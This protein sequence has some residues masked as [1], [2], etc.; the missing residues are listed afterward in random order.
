MIVVEKAPGI[1]GPLPDWIKNY[2]LDNLKTLN[3]QLLLNNSIAGVGK[4]KVILADQKTFPNAMC[5]WAAGVK[6]PEFLQQLNV[7]KTPQGR[8][9]VDACLRIRDNCFVTGDNAYFTYKNNSLRMAVQFAITQG[10]LTASNIIRQIKGRPL[11]QYKPVDFGYIIPM[12][13]N[14]SCGEILGIKLKGLLPTLLHYAMSA[15]R[16]YGFKNR[17]GII[18]GL[19][20]AKRP[21]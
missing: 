13:N 5:I 6:T 19:L 14:K 15:Y 9:K 21:S 18:K 20:K 8:L 17:L 12:A 3:I 16:S 2:V 11:A 7:D 4:D 10:E 1:L